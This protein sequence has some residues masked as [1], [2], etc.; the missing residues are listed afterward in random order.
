MWY[1]IKYYFLKIWFILLLILVA[2]FLGIVIYLNKNELISYFEDY[3][4]KIEL[5]PKEYVSKDIEDV[6]TYLEDLK[7]GAPYLKDITKY[8]PSSQKS[9]KDNYIQKVKENP[10]YIYKKKISWAD[11]SLTSDQYKELLE[12]VGYKLNNNGN[13][14]ITTIVSVPTMEELEEIDQELMYYTDNKGVLY[15]NLKVEEIDETLDTSKI[16]CYTFRLKYDME[17]NVTIR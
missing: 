13:S 9:D 15:L 7:V 12:L 14:N 8:I 4:N 5:K 1:W 17:G 16:F 2:S 6:D 11:G 10:D 3:T